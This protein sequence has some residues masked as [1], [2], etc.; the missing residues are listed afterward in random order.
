MTLTKSIFYMT[1]YATFFS[2]FQIA[3]AHISNTETLEENY[4]RSIEAPAEKAMVETWENLTLELKRKEKFLFK[5]AEENDVLSIETLLNEGVDVEARDSKGRTALHIAAQ[6]NS[7]GAIEALEKAGADLEARYFGM[8]PLFYSSERGHKEATKT[9]LRLGADVH[10]KSRNLSPGRTVMHGAA[11]DSNS[12]IIR[13]LL[14]AG[15]NL[16]ARNDDGDTPLIYVAR[17]GMGQYEMI[18]ILINFGANIEARNNVGKTA[19]DYILTSLK[20]DEE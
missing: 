12:E 16:E 15:A 8:T 5:A 11:L 19:Q 20:L 1:L 17:N 14:E 18:R 4:V 10:A 13:I 3:Y 6:S 7:S 9:L 2:F